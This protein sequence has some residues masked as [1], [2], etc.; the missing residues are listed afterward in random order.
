MTTESLSIIVTF[1]VYLVGLLVIGRLSER[2]HSGSYQDFVSAGKSLGGVVTALSAAASSESVWV[3]LGLSGL[4]YWKGAA[5]LWAAFGCIIG[6]LFNAVAIT[7]PLRRDSA[8]LGSLTVSD[9]IASRLGDERGVL[10]ILSSLIITFFMLSYVVAQF[11]GAGDLIHGMDLLGPDTPYWIGVV[12]GAIIIALYV[13]MGGYAAVCWTDSVQGVLM[14]LVM[15]GL[16]I[17]ALVLAGGWSGMEAVLGPLGLFELN[18][19]EGGSWA[20][21]GF[22]VGQLGIALGYPGMPHMIVRYMT[23]T[24]DKEARLSGVVSVVWASVVLLGSTLLGMAVRSLMPEL[25]ADQKAAEQLVIP[26]FSRTYLHPILTGVV[27]SAVTAAIM[28]TADSQLM[29]AA[30]SVLNDLRGKGQPVSAEAPGMVK[31]T[32]W[33]ILGMSA[34]AMVIALLKMR[35]IYTFVLF[36]WGAL[37]AA[38]TPII[39][40]GL[41]WK[42]LTR[43]GALAS[44]IVGPTVV[45][46][47]YY[48]PALHE[49]VYELIPAFGLSLLSAVVVSLLTYQKE[50][51]RLASIA[52]IRESASS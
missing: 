47:W 48:I 18:A 42:K 37:G 25:A 6:F 35:L 4:G 19:V 51:T 22:I 5:A 17:Y 43:Q 1:A 41:Y 44:L 33:V 11:T 2:K 15:L 36:A 21:L 10:R 52:A 16:P 26:M 7:V 13:V 20:L 9:Y 50:Q 39:V 24:D 40:L 31:K 3:M 23:V 46:S 27:L 8:R 32:R 14:F 49:A 45:V 28:S 34:I 30:T 29:Y 38:F 12:V